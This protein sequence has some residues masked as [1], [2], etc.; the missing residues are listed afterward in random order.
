VPRFRYTI[1]LRPSLAS[2]AV[3]DGAGPRVPT[4]CRSHP[5]QQLAAWISAHI[6]AFE[7]FSGVPRLLVPDNLRT[8]SE[9]CLPAT[10]RIST[11]LPKSCD[12]LR[13]GSCAGAPSSSERQGQ[14]RSRRANCRNAWILPPYATRSFFGWRILNNAI[15][16]LLER[17][18][19]DRSGKREGSACQCGSLRLNATL[20][21][22]LPSSRST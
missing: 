16:E 9:P 8:G 1:R 3:R 6:H 12:A 11:H 20:W 22:A 18:T 2:L 7:Y 15:R 14:G 17:L 4:V 5:G 10:I 21:R 19:S 13:R